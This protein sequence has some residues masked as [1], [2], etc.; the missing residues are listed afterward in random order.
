MLIYIQIIAMKGENCLL[1]IGAGKNVNTFISGL[2]SSVKSIKQDVKVVISPA[3]DIEKKLLNVVRGRFKVVLT[4][5]IRRHYYA[6]ALL[7]F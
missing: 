5:G 2:Y 3:G 6:T 1:M 4:R 7:W